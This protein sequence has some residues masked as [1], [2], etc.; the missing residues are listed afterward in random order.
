MRE[1][2]WGPG[3]AAGGAP[4]IVARPLARPNR[5]SRAVAEGGAVP[6]CWSGSTDKMDY[7]NLG[8][9]LAPILIAAL[10]GRGVERLPMRSVATRL[11]GVG[12]VG[13]GLADGETFVWGAGCGTHRV[14]AGA[15]VPYRRPPDT[16][17]RLFATRGP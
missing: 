8:D 6:L 13:H 17:F 2:E 14:E 15:S 9:A 5:L 4:A 16:A 1:G 12:Y 7:V 10:T 11:A 3:A